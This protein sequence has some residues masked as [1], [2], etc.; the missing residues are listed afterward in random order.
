MQNKEVKKTENKVEVSA[1]TKTTPAW[2]KYDYTTVKGLL[3]CGATLV[4][5]G[6]ERKYV[7]NALDEDIIESRDDVFDTLCACFAAKENSDQ[8]KVGNRYY[9]VTDYEIPAEE[10]LY[11]IVNFSHR[12][13]LSDKAFGKGK[14]VELSTIDNS[15]NED[16]VLSPSGFKEALKVF[17]EYGKF[18]QTKPIDKELQKLSNFEALL[19]D[20]EDTDVIE[21]LYNDDCDYSREFAFLLEVRL[22]K[23]KG[24]GIKTETETR[25]VTVHNYLGVKENGNNEQ[26]DN[27]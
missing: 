5:S 24:F 16:K 18:E 25:K 6:K 1:T 20:A 11:R 13:S 27:N 3:I 21:E 26:G 9:D 2:R 23:V 19:T 7:W 15:Y 8:V 17:Q 22:P 10:W 4:A 14:Y 12:V